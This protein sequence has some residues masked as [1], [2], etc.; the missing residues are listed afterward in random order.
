M[1]NTFL[2]FNLALFTTITFGQTYPIVDTDVNEFYSDSDKINAPLQNQPYYGQDATYKGNK[3]SYTNNQDGTITDNITGLMWEQ[4]MGDK[5][6]F[7]EAFTKAQESTLADYSDWRVPTLKE[8]YSLILF[9]GQVKGE[10]AMVYFIDTNYFEQAL[11]N[12]SIGEREIDAQTWSSTEY[13]GTTMNGNATVFGVNFIDGRIKGYPKYKKSTGAANTMYFRM[14]RGNSNYGI[15]NFTNNNDGTITDIATGLMWQ[16]ADDGFTR[17]WEEALAYAE[18]FELADYNDW[19]LPN[20]KELQS[21]VDYS[22]SPKTSNSP[23]I[24]PMFECTEITDPDGNSG[25]YGF[26]WT[27]TSHLD[28]ANPYSNA[29]YIA[30]GEGM[31]QMNG[32]LLDVHGAGCQRSD[33]KSGNSSDYPDFWGPQGDVRYVY[34]FVRCVRNVESSTSTNESPILNFNIYPN[35]SNN[36]FTIKADSKI[37][38]IS[39]YTTLGIESNRYFPTKNEITIISSHYPKG[40]YIVQIT[41]IYGNIHSNKLLI[42][43]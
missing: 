28:G 22:R 43:D 15:N 11:G 9:T 3:P 6:T 27:G 32:T 34:N 38:S 4:S 41:D 25:Q 2:I 12:V 35:P 24:D 7:D 20:A 16:T 42:E 39:I 5:I 36:S 13:V 40:L 30:F 31:G 1:K 23:A 33:P 26:Y 21:I 18:A 10:T 14:V 8:L 19:R 17:N 37:K 29:V